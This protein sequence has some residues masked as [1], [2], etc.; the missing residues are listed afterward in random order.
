MSVRPQRRT[1]IVLLCYQAGIGQIS[2]TM[3]AAL[4]RMANKR[5][6]KSRFVMLSPFW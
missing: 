5:T 3:I 4:T 6:V 2:A 1:L